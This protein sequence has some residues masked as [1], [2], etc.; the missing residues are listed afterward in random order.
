MQPHPRQIHA[1]MRAKGLRQRAGGGGP[2]ADT[3]VTIADFLWGPVALLAN[4]L[5]HG[6]P[7]STVAGVKEIIVSGVGTAAWAVA[8]SAIGRALGS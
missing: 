3:V 4:V 7:P 1:V 8:G 2:M 5:Q 6:F